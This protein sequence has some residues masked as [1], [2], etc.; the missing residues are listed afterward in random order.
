[1]TQ[2]WYDDLLLREDVTSDL[3]TAESGRLLAEELRRRGSNPA[4]EDP[5]VAEW[6]GRVDVLRRGVPELGWPD[7]DETL[8]DEIVGDACQGKTSLD[9]IE[10]MDLV[11]FLEGRLD[12]HQARELRESARSRW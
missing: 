7:F 10:R 8:L 3:D 9:Q 11:P 6:L 1:M 12:R 2:V 5:R 4:L